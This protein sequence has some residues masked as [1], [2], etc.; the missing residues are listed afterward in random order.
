MISIQ[1]L[2]AIRDAL[3]PLTDNVFHYWR[4]Q[5]SAPYIIWEETSEDDSFH[6]DNL[7]AEQA[8]RG[9]VDLYSKEEFDPLFDDIQEAL[10]SIDGLGWTLSDAQYEDETGL[11]HHTWEWVIV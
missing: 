6:A 5:M 8:I 4:P 11:I 9:T 3:I 2:M 10:N 1:R 7:K